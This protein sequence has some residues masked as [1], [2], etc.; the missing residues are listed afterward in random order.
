MIPPHGG[1][2]VDRIRLDTPG[3]RDQADPPHLTLSEREANDLDMI[4]SGAMSPLQG[5]MAQRDYQEVCRNRRLASGLPWPLPVVLS[6]KEGDAQPRPGDLTALHDRQGNLRGTIEVDDVYQIDRE[7][8]AELCLGTTSD[9]HPGVGYLKR[10]GDTYVGGQVTVLARPEQAT[11]ASYRLDPKD[12]RELFEAKGWKSI[13]A[14]QTRNPIHRAHEYLTKCALETVDALL[15]HP[16]VG[17]TSPDDIPAEVRMQ[18]YEAIL[19]RYYPEDRVALTVYPQ[20]MRY[21]GPRE[22]LLHALIRKNYGCTHFIVGRDHAGTGD[23]YG[24][25]DAHEIFDDFDPDEIAIAPLRFDHAYWCKRSG[26]MASSRSGPATNADERVF[27]SGTKLREMLEKGE[28]PPE[29]FTRP[30][31]ARIL[32]EYY[33]ERHHP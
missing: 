15:V 28:Y 3:F 12:T 14:F 27:L 29:E 22:A 18:C 10:N 8:E 32:I 25:Y 20:A 31:I 13:V 5:F 11:F 1:Q 21:A 19:S 24:T 23:F 16:L 2:L 26:G 33:A 7:T 17:E 30:E 4:G 6:V 9:N